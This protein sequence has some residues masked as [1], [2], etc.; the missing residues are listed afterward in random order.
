MSEQSSGG[1]SGDW[2]G[3][4]SGGI[5]GMGIWPSQRGL[6]RFKCHLPSTSYMSG[7]LLLLACSIFLTTF[8]DIYQLKATDEL[9]EAQERCS[10][11]LTTPKLASLTELGL[12]HK[13]V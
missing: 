3:A 4:A 5:C 11:W 10:N 6:L 1:V 9:T 13:T 12:E 8:E 2:K 7:A